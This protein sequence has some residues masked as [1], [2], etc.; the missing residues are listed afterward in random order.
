MNKFMSLVMALVFSV[1]LTMVVGFVI[2]SIKGTPYAFGDAIP[3]GLII[4][5]VMFLFALTFKPGEGE[6]EAHH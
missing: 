3:F 1:I 2:S 5:I 4:G 6:G